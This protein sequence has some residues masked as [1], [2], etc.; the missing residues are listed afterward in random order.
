MVTI[1]NTL[2]QRKEPLRPLESGKVRLYV[3]GMT[4]YDFCHLG[5]ARMLLAFDVVV[6]YL[7][8]S[9]YDV[10]YVRNITDVDDKILARAVED[11]EPF[12][13]IT[14]RFIGA[15]HE[16]EAALSIVRPDQEP[17]ATAHIDQMVN[18]IKKLLDSDHAYRADNGDVYFSVSNFP[19]YGKL[20]KK[21]PDELLEGAR[22]KVGELKR[23]PRDFVLW[24]NAGD[25]TVGWD[26]PW[27][28]GRPGWHIECSAMSTCALG[29]TFDIHGG[30]SDLMFPHHENEIAQSEA[31]TGSTF[32]KVWMHNGPLRIDDEKMS[33][34]LGNFLTVREV[35]AS[36]KPEIV[37]YLLV[38]SHYRSPINYSENSL[39]QSV[40]AVERFYHCLKDLNL[41]DSKTLTNSRFEKAFRRAMDDDFN[42]PQALSVLFE[43][44]SEIHQVK[45]EDQAL[46]N[47]LGALLV[48]LGGSLGLLQADPAVF[49]QYAVGADIDKGEIDR[50]V[51]ER[52]AARAD[53]NWQR[54]DEIRE[55]LSDLNVVIEDGAEGSTWRI[56]G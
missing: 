2:T 52:V 20:S 8:F 50:L 9:G 56:K 11:K 6:R 53:E 18:M 23:D 46:A 21:K 51:N 4:V 55:Q 14:D 3:C 43:I 1:Y 41:A 28:Y 40:K 5:H 22:V 13:A 16:D 12:T 7:R 48:R 39:D 33:K 37:R 47:Q 31:A 29:D 30:G 17:R 34:S 54:A 45:G 38:S 27:G 49:L 26:S 25:E 44:V 32:A 42:T 19:D 35:L 36:Y 24:K 15:M 10:T